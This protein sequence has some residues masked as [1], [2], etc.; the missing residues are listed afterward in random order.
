MPSRAY[1]FTYNQYLTGQ[2]KEGGGEGRGAGQFEA[3]TITVCSGKTLSHTAFLSTTVTN[4]ISVTG[5]WCYFTV[6]HMHRGM[7]ERIMGIVI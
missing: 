1:K 4:A 7:Q 5:V 3:V 2:I 6:K